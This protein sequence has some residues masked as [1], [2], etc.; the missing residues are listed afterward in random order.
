M[1][2]MTHPTPPA[3]LMPEL[4]ASIQQQRTEANMLD[5]A[6]HFGITGDSNNL[7]DKDWCLTLEAIDQAHPGWRFYGASVRRFDDVYSIQEAA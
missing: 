4:L 1:K 5:A 6:Q 3:Q 7:S 2:T